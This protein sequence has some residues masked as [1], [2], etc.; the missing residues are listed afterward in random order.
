LTVR[1]LNLRLCFKFLDRKK[2]GEFMSAVVAYKF[3]GRHTSSLRIRIMNSRNSHNYTKF[4][5]SLIK[6]AAA[7]RSI[8]LPG[9]AGY[10]IE[11]WSAHPSV[12]LH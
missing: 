12:T 9:A 7:D 11:E 3:V 8:L 2:D 1:A 6:K 4:E 10:R 5:I